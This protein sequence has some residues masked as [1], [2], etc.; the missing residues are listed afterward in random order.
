MTSTTDSEVF[1]NL[2][3]IDKPAEKYEKFT[4]I[5]ELLNASKI[6]ISDILHSFEFG[7][8]IIISDFL[9]FEDRKQF[10]EEYWIESIWPSKGFC[11]TFDSKMHQ[12][13]K[14]DIFTKDDSILYMKLKFSVS[15]RQFQFFPHFLKI[16]FLHR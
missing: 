5:H 2:F 12:M 4:N 13:D 10:L 16:E 3:Q 6:G 9:T 1:G 7:T 15:E 8:K 11:Y 14:L